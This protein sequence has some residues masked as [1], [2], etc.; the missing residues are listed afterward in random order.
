ML[1]EPTTLAAVATAVA[2]GIESYGLDADALFAQAELDKQKLAIPGA[3]YRVRRMRRLWALA[4]QATGDPCF[5]LVVSRFIKPTSLHALGFSWLASSTLRD[6][7]ERLVRYARIVSTG[8]QLE[9]ET[10]SG[11]CTLSAA[12]QIPDLQPPPEA[13]DAFL[14]LIVR[15]CRIMASDHFAPRSV[16][17]KHP[18]NGHPEAYV[19]LFQAPVEFGADRNTLAFNQEELDAPLRASNTE[20][21]FEN[22]R[23]AERYLQSLN[24]DEVSTKVRELLLELL[25]SGEASE[26][27]IAGTLNRSV[28]S[29]RRT[30]RSEGVR[31]RD[32]LKGT[33]QSMA[34]QYVREGKYS[35]GQIAFLLGF[36]DQSNFSRAFKR[37]TG[38]TPKAFRTG[39]RTEIR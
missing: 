28:S 6:G 16:A 15:M 27:K 35:L 38:Y 25:P 22:D 11:I 23:I 33:R 4:R 14:A 36:S 34:E 21:A 39:I 10:D 17:F 18:D 2:Q 12:G 3:R 37:W 8:A 29:L 13:V 7:L 20:L 5:G 31:Y 30:L 32:L 26:K 9:L 19:E 24:P 1:S